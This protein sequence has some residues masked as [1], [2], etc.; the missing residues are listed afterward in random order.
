MDNSKANL[1]KIAL[2]ATISIAALFALYKLTSGKGT[3]ASGA[4][5]N[6][7]SK[8]DYSEII[9]QRLPIEEKQKQAYEFVT[10][11]IKKHIAGRNLKVQADGKFEAEDFKKLLRIMNFYAQSIIYDIKIRNQQERIEYLESDLSQ[12]VDLMKTQQS[13]EV[14]GY[15]DALTLICEAAKINQETFMKTYGNEAP[16]KE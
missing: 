3:A 8:D 11:F 4:R 7:T 6:R 15:N 2:G 1:I 13:S 5:K 10:D 12:Y 9:D 14:E 16:G